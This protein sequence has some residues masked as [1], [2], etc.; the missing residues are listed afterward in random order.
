M[1]SQAQKGGDGSGRR[2]RLATPKGGATSATAAGGAKP[3]QTPAS[4]GGDGWKPRA[5]AAA[6]IAGM[7]L[8]G[9]SLGV[10]YIAPDLAR[11]V[12]S[13]GVYAVRIAG[14]ALVLLGWW[15][16]RKAPKARVRGPL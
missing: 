10:G 13:S 15:L 14:V 3:P 8:A 5:S 12:G 4:L 9:L 6:T 7:M 11:T 2:R 1:A 16:G